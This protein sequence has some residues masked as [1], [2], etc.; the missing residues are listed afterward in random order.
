MCVVSAVV[1]VVPGSV[2]AQPGGFGDVPDDAYYSVPVATLAERGVFVDTECEDGF[3]PGEAI[4][5][6]TIAVWVVR[7]LDGADP[8]P[9]TESR[10]DDVDTSSLFHAPFI[11]RMADLGVTRGCGDGS[12]FCPDRDVSRAEMAVFVSRAYE[13]PDGPDPGFGDVPSDAWY[14]AE[15]AEL[16]ASRI[17]VGCGD[18]TVFC[19]GRDTTRGEMA[20]FLYRA[21][22]RKQVMAVQLNPVMDGGGVIAAGA[23]HSCGLRTDG[24][25]TCWGGN[26]GGQIN[27]P[28]GTFTA[29]AAGSTHSCGL[30]T[31][32]TVT[33]WGWNNHGQARAPSGRFSAVTG[34]GGYSCWLRADRTLTC[35]GEN[36]YGETQAPAGEF[37]AVSA[38][39]SHACGLR[40]DKT[41]T[42]WGFDANGRLSAPAGEF[43]AVSAGAAHSCALRTD[44]TIKCWG[45][46]I[47]GQTT[48]PAGE[49]IAVSAGSFY[50]CGLRTDNTVTC[51][52]SNHYGLADAPARAFITI[53]SGYDHAC[54]LRIDKTVACWGTDDNPFI[55]GPDVVPK[56][57]A[58]TGHFGPDSPPTSSTSGWQSA[59]RR[60]RMPKPETVIQK[61]RTT[62][63]TRTRQNPCIRCENRHR[64]CHLTCV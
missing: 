63:R 29:V 36:R 24:T 10:F 19:P 2:A 16:A 17:T 58:P 46:S 50:S 30:R 37:A 11:E 32:G 52:G 9:V 60:D 26:S 1:A 39:S 59:P 42:C 61:A 31:D 21:E 49:F 53:S 20:T 3:C 38:G 45:L 56:T 54:G 12:G 41:I 62:R 57:N 43:A 4:D 51:W 35:R 47:H 34:G 23:T 7:V 55:Y 27:A 6:K 8:A 28:S 13:L 15:V 64:R 44:Q 22:N 40:T 48:P 33:C 25:V 18:G 14:A 5:R